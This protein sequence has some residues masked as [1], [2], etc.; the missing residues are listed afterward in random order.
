MGKR[1]PKV[2]AR[3]LELLKGGE[4]WKRGVLAQGVLNPG[5]DA[6]D[7]TY[8]EVSVYDERAGAFCLIGACARAVYEVEGVRPE[9][10]DRIYNDEQL[11]SYYELLRECTPEQH[12]DKHG[13]GAST[14]EIV[15]NYNDSINNSFEKI[16]AVLTCAEKR[17]REETEADASE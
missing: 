11:V 15:Y 9:D 1:N 13:P 3:A 4:G 10:A 7:R 12:R 16:E 17:A 14:A 6:C 8:G 2:Y 5:D